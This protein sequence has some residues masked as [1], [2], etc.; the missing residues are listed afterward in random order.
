MMTGR[1]VLIVVA[2]IAALVLPIALVVYNYSGEE[3]DVYVTVLDKGYTPA[4]ST[5]YYNANTKSTMFRHTPE[6]HNLRV[7]WSGERDWVPVSESVY[8]AV[9]VGDEV[10]GTVRRG[11]IT[12]STIFTVTL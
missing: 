9:A 4:H 5:P 3:Q 1:N 7:E 12:G 6:R 11:R 8:D 10:P 2:V